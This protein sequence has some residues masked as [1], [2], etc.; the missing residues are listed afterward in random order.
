MTGVNE[1]LTLSLMRT[2]R[3]QIESVPHGLSIF[4]VL[5][6][7]LGGSLEFL[8]RVGFLSHAGISETEVVVWLK[9]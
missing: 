6:L 5:V 1:V 8:L 2:R 4:D 3:W 9:Q 7:K